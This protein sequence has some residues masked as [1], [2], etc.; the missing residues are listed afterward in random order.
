MSVER[1]HVNLSPQ[2]L[3]VLA[4][5]D[6]TAA[7][8]DPGLEER[9]VTGRPRRLLVWPR[10]RYSVALLVGGIAV[11]AMTVQ[12]SVWLAFVGVVMMTVALEGMAV[13]FPA[14]AT[15]VYRWWRSEV[16]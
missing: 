10:T 14:F 1:D 15:R 9:M 3:K 8:S 4:R 12:I 7:A 2:E 16:I 11:A 13:A 6:A 5:L